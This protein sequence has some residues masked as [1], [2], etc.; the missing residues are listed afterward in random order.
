MWLP[1]KLA[2]QIAILEEHPEYAAVHSDSSYVDLEGRTLQASVNPDRQSR[3][4]TVFDE[5][6]ASNMSLALTSS[7]VIR[8]TCLDAVGLFDKR[9]V[10]G[11]DWDLL[12]R[13][14]ARYP[15]WFVRYPLVKYRLTP[16]SLTR[17]NVVRNIAH[18]EAC[19]SQFIALNSALFEGKRRML[20]RRWTHFYAEAAD[21]LFAYRQYRESHRCFREALR[22]RPSARTAL[23]FALTTLPPALL[24]RLAGWKRSLSSSQRNS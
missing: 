23:Y 11:E 24:E 14:S 19:L 13:L 21:R 7:V 10:G 12:L 9:Y 15:I 18:R 2:V 8:R 3:N 5:F 20:R 6:F 4:G 22:R 16:G 1:E 17:G